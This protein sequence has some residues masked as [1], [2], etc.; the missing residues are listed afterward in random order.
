M[1]LLRRLRHGDRVPPQHENLKRPRDILQAQWPKLLELQTKATMNMVPDRSG[2]ANAAGRTL[3]LKPGDH[4]YGIAM[5]VS[6]I[7]NGVANVYADA[8]A[9]GSVKWLI[10][11]YNWDLLLDLHCAAYRSINAVEHD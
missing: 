11:I 3:G 4:V 2:H 9:D 8:E 10:A 6:P 5:Q 1:R 7:W